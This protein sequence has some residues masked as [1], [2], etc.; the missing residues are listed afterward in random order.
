LTIGDRVRVKV[1]QQV[2]ADGVLIEG[3]ASFNQASITGEFVPVLKQVNDSVF[4]GSIVVDSSVIVEVLKNPSDSIVQKMITFVKDAQ[5][6]KTKS[7]KRITLFEKVYVYVVIL[8]S[9]FVIFVV[10]QLGWLTSDEAFRRGIIVLVVASPCA[11]VAS[12]TPGILS[13]LSHGARHGI[14]VKSG[15]YLEKIQSIDVV[16]FDKTGTITTG[17]PHVVNF[18]HLDRCDE[19]TLLNVLVNAERLSNHPLAKAIVKHFPHVPRQTYV[20]KEIPGRGM[21]LEF[22]G[23]VWRIG[24]FPVS[25]NAEL[26]VAIQQAQTHG[27]TIVMVTRDEELV[28]YVSLIDTVRPGID[29]AIQALKQLGVLPVMLTGDNAFT[30]KKIAHF[31]GIDTFFSECLPDDKVQHIQTFK[32]KGHRVLMVGDGINDAPSLVTAD[33]GVAMGDGTDVSLETADV[34][35]MNNNLANIPYLMRISRRMKTIIFQNVVFSISVITILLIANLFGLVLLTY[36]V[37]GHELST[38]LVILNSLRLLS[39]RPRDQILLTK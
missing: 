17:V 10:P 31:V 6:Q 34:V 33:L 2:P 28:G 24:R 20:S 8:L 18:K 29:Q 38:I 12:I 11:L 13:T 23:H 32:Q 35:M 37:L 9:L 36:G 7:E 14:L 30:A 22:E 3:S 5:E 1:G 27:E 19:E 26:E 39:D 21:E 16:A 15:Q 25:N 4:A